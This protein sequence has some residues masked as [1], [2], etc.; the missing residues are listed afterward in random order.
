MLT[1]DIIEIYFMKRED[2]MKIFIAVICAVALLSAVLITRTLVIR[3]KAKKP[4]AEKNHVAPEK[5]AVMGHLLRVNAEC[6]PR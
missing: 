1:D 6:R 3:A 2:Y 4:E 5:Q